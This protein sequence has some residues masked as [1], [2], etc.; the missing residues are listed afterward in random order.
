MKKDNFCE[1]TAQTTT[2]LNFSERQIADFSFLSD[3]DN[4]AKVDLAHNQIFDLSFLS[5][6]TQLTQINLASNRIFALT[7]LLT[8]KKL[9]FLDL[10]GNPVSDL[11]SLSNLT[12]LTIK[13]KDGQLQIF[14]LII[15]L[16][17][18][19]IAQLLG[20]MMRSGIGMEIGRGELFHH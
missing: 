15:G 16:N 6:L 19:S 17:I 3:S 2:E 20:K 9:T 12:N 14:P 4:I 8:L 5:H 13:I 18:Y 10:T 11:I 7:P 1:P